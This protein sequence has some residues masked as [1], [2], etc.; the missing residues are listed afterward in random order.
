VQVA[1]ACARTLV[2][3]FLDERPLEA[4]CAA[5]ERVSFE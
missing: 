4:A 5:A 3:H 1:S 2:A